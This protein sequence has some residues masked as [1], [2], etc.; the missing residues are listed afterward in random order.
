VGSELIVIEKEADPKRATQIAFLEATDIPL[1]GADEQTV[2]VL[3]TRTGDGR[4][5]VS[6]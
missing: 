6:F 3:G 2:G 4:A 5:S 1:K